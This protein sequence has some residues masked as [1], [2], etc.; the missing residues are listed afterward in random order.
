MGEEGN[1]RAWGAQRHPPPSPALPFNPYL[2]PRRPDDPSQAEATK[3]TKKAM[4]RAA[5]QQHQQ[6]GAKA[7]AGKGPGAMQQEANKRGK[8]KR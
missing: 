7:A 3:T 4:D 5:A 2:I 6:A 8:K 1:S